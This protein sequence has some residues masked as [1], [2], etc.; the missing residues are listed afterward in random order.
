MYTHLL[1]AVYGRDLIVGDNRKKLVETDSI[2]LVK[3]AASVL[4][5][6]VL[7]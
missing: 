2:L 3:Y 5:E 4:T 7:D 6:M 1:G